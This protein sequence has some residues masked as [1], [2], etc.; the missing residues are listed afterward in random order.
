MIAL[1]IR[2][3]HK[4]SVDTSRLPSFK[5]QVVCYQCSL[6]CSLI[7]VQAPAFHDIFLRGLGNLVVMVQLDTD[8]F[9][10]GTSDSLRY[11]MKYEFESRLRWM[12]CQPVAFS[13]TE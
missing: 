1:V 13:G 2:R 12:I 9:F 3:P 5:Q 4:I 11:W 6:P 8:I 10:H 7:R